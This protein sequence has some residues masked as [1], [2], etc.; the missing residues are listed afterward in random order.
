MPLI[1]FTV[2]MLIFAACATAGALWWE[3]RDASPCRLRGHRGCALCGLPQPSWECR[4]NNCGACDGIEC[5]H[6]CH[7]PVP[8]DV[9][10]GRAA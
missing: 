2:G 4:D 9:L 1:V 5:G 8:A 7:L 6:R 10:E 3:R